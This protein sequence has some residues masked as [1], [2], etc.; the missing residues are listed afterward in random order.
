LKKYSSGIIQAKAWELW[1][2][3]H[4]FSQ[5]L[6]SPGHYESYCKR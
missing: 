3:S 2:W 5:Q 4:L 1:N 6:C